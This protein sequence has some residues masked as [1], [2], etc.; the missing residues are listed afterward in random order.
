MSKISLY[1]YKIFQ[2]GTQNYLFNSF[3]KSIFELDD[4]VY[5]ALQHSSVEDDTCISEAIQKEFVD[6][7]LMV[8]EQNQKFYLDYIAAKKEKDGFNPT[9]LTLMISQECNLRCIYCYGNGGE[10]NKRGLMNFEVAKQAVD[11][12]VKNSKSND[13]SVV[14]FGGEPL[15]NFTLM[16]QVV[17]YCKTISSKTF[18]YSITTN[19]LLITPE[20]ESFL[21]EN[22]FTIQI[23]MDGDE[24]TQNCN[25]FYANGKGCYQD[26][27]AHTESLRKQGKLSVRAT[28]SKSNMEISSNV[29][30]LIELGFRRVFWSPAYNLLEDSDYEILT[31]QVKKYICEFENLVSSGDIVTAKKYGNVTSHLKKIHYSRIGVKLCG[32]GNHMIAVDIDGLIYPCHRFVGNEPFCFGDV[33]SENISYT[34]FFNDTYIDAHKQCKDCWCKN[35]CIGGCVYTNFDSAGQISKSNILQCKFMRDTWEYLIGLYL[36]LPKDV[37]KELGV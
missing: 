6:S 7:N 14:F 37:L 4:D 25:R 13:L 11:F 32:C 23:S 22:K 36:R 1:P 24:N 35:L 9:S 15:L 26:V 33:F 5:D 29:S 12:L 3:N 28:I 20:V 27:L 21:L 19:G 2:T 30:H 17:D 10:Y 18:T 34:S 31:Q 16:K 8:T